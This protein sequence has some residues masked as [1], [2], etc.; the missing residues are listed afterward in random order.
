ML[1]TTE[2]V[3][4]Q[5]LLRLDPIIRVL[6]AFEDEHRRIRPEHLAHSREYRNRCV[7]YCAAAVLL[8][9]R[10]TVHDEGSHRLDLRQH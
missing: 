10:K 9:V 3:L 4:V 6:V 1:S 5:L 7:V 8:H 2:P